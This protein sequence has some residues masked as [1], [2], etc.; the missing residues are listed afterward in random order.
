MA[1][2]QKNTLGSK[3]N[4]SLK[5]HAKDETDYGTEYVDLP[6]GIKGGIATFTEGKIG[7][8]KSGTYEGEQFCYLAGVIVSPKEITYAPKTFSEGKVVV[9]PLETVK[10]EGQ[11]TSIMIP[12]CDTKNAKGEV[13]DADAHIE[14]MMNEVRKI[15]GEKCTAN[16]VSDEGLVAL[17]QTLAEV[18][19]IFKFGTTSSEPNE[20]YPTPRVWENWH[21]AKGLDEEDDPTD[22]EDDV[23]DNTEEE[24]V[25]DEA[26]DQ[27][28]EEE[29]EEEED[30]E[31]TPEALV[32]LGVTADTD[33]T[34]EGGNAVAQLNQFAADEGFD[35]ND[36]ETF[37][38]LAEAL[39]NEAEDVL[40]DAE[41]EDE[42]E[43]DEEEDEEN[44]VDTPVVG[45]IKNFKPK[46]ARK[47]TEV[48][49]KT[50]N[51]AKQTCTLM[52]LSDQKKYSNIAWDRLED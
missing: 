39:V 24:E 31:M 42:D 23:D 4:N 29:E 43:E 38:L 27:E 10:V 35:P 52:R 11:R 18:G 50:V 51:N 2:V 46:G 44:E 22:D 26:E 21:G 1:K 37:E 9:L 32:A 20:A 3:L 28:V 30:E 8:Y 5:K 36:Y 15:G 40:K 7:T 13:T 6:P 34:K 12:M 41:D 14:R 16:I 25:E 17:F 48:E 47:L 45:E 19:P 49:V 33:E